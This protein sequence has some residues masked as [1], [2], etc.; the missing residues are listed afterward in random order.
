[1]RTLIVFLAGCLA[2]GATLAVQIQS[3][4]RPGTLQAEEAERQPKVP[5]QYNPRAKPPDPAKLKSEAEELNKLAASI[6]ADMDRASKGLLANDL[7]AR[8]KRI[9]K[10]SKKL[11]TEISP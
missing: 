3:I 2:C 5:P 6:P 11:R 1:M 7:I 4:H 10:L 8:L 9:E